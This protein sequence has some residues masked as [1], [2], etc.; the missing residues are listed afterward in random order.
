MMNYGKFAYFFIKTY[1]LSAYE[2]SLLDVI[3]MSSHN[4][5]YEELTKIISQL[6]LYYHMG[7]WDFCCLCLF[8]CVFMCM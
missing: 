6:S 8:L 2:N 1:V 7:S 5:L 3:L 4:M